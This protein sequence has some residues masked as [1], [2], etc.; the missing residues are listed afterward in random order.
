MATPTR[1]SRALTGTLGD[2]LVDIR[3]VPARAPR[4]AVVLLHGFKGFK[5]WGF[6]PPLADR[7]ARAGF[8]TVSYNA[9]GSGVDAT[10][11]FAFP[12]RFG[13]N[14]FSAE[15]SDLQTIL[16]ALESGDLGVIPPTA[17]GLLG[18][19]RGGGIAILE[20]ARRATVRALVTWAAIASPSRWPPETR[21]RWR[22][23]GHLPVT[24]QRTGEVLSVYPDI[25]DDLDQHPQ[26]LDIAASAARLSIPWLIV[27]GEVDETVP[28]TEGKALHAAAPGATFLPVP[29][30]GH[31]FGASHPLA[32]WAA[33]L[34]QV[35]DA[36]V[37][38][39]GRH[40]P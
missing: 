25:L 18:H 34:V 19:S 5:D 39:L 3:A 10:G 35:V 29:R 32:G 8:T 16:D 4:P 26:R 28:I 2:I 40:L 17:L 9:S 21:R 24:N 33:P 22:E 12:E 1:L 30:T 23:A 15:L 31:T 13:H 20:A 14:T 36:S 38:F 6:F 11:T 27:H 37:E 7:L